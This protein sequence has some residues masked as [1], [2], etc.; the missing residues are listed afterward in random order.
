MGVDLYLDHRD[1]HFGQRI[2]PASV[3][4]TALSAVIKALMN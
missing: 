1:A 4:T 3:V 2:W